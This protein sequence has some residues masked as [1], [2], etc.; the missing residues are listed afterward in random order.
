MSQLTFQ[1][2]GL[3]SDGFTKNELIK[4]LKKYENVV[5]DDSFKLP[6]FI[7]NKDI[8]IQ[9][10]S[11][12]SGD[13]GVVYNA[14]CNNNKCDNNV[15]IKSPLFG[16]KKAKDIITEFI[17]EG[18]IMSQLKH[19]NIVKMMGIVTDDFLTD[20][21]SLKIVLE[22]CSHGDLLSNLKLRKKSNSSSAFLIIQR[23][24]RNI[25]TNLEIGFDILTGMEHLSTN[26]IL[27]NDLAA[28]NILI[29]IENG[30]VVCKI[31]DFGLSLM[32]NQHTTKK[33]LKP[34]SWAAPE[35]FINPPNLTEKSDVWS[36]GAV[37]IEII[38]NGEPPFTVCHC[39]RTR[40]NYNIINDCSK[41][42]K[43]CKTKR[44]WSLDQKKANTNKN[45]Q[46]QYS[47][48]GN[49]KSNHKATKGKTRF[50]SGYLDHLDYFIKNQNPKHK[51]KENNKFIQTIIQMCW[52]NK[53]ASRPS[54]KNLYQLFKSEQTKKPIISNKQNLAFK[55]NL[56]LFR[57]V[58]DKYYS[59]ELKKLFNPLI[60]NDSVINC[61]KLFKLIYDI[62]K[63]RPINYLHPTPNSIYSDIFGK[64]T[65]SDTYYLEITNDFFILE[66]VFKAIKLDYSNVCN[67][68]NKILQ[69]GMYDNNDNNDN[70]NSQNEYNNNSQNVNEYNN[71]K[72][73]SKKSNEYNNNSQNVNE[74]N[75]NSQ[76]VNEYNNNSQNVNSKSP[77]KSPS[78]LYANDNQHNFT[79]INS[80]NNDTEK[81]EQIR[82]KS[83]GEV[84]II[85][86]IDTAMLTTLL[87]NKQC[88]IIYG[89]IN[90]YKKSLGINHK[91][92]IIIDKI[93]KK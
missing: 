63:K 35:R 33:I 64:E 62:V 47:R 89:F 18:A 82:I 29:N 92:A 45:P 59:E 3:S 55:Q 78:K 6:N 9:G 20:N 90:I 75:N 25:K 76:N 16:K 53:I 21:S 57:G 56:V 39:L 5:N 48:L 58:S 22:K 60:S 86:N 87:E 28:R 74:Y 73:Q 40:D 32:Y 85:P 36:F 49:S 77:S 30:N 50:V 2:I 66:Q 1:D 51:I 34:V 15:V 42:S 26:K 43:P 12:G 38:T 69:G 79:P 31:G 72:P 81:C 23:N 11:I 19:S 52:N 13:F 68:N 80:N 7:N 41:H 71:A 83:K 27:H 8:K 44:L 24:T 54:V 70:N 91:N 93:N 17:C 88:N 46:S 37:L 14:T 84:D 4:L 61:N 10:R 67:C 65:V